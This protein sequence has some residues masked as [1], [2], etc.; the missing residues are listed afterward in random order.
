MSF[1]HRLDRDPSPFLLNAW[2][3]LAIYQELGEVW[4]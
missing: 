1:L 4:S 3:Q 2:L